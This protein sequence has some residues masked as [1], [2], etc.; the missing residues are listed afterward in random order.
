MKSDELEAA[1][2]LVRSRAVK[3]SNTMGRAVGTDVGVTIGVA[4][5]LIRSITAARDDLVRAID[6]RDE[7]QGDRA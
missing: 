3:L 7:I 6:L 2:L 4:N 1:E 5:D